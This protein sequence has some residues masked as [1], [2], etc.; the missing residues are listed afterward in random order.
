[1]ND[2][3]RRELIRRRWLLGTTAT[4]AAALGLGAALWRSRFEPDTAAES[5]PTDFWSLKWADPSGKTVSMQ[6]FRGQRLVLNF[7]ATWCPPCVEELPLI[8]DFYQKNKGNGWQVVGLAID[9]PSAVDAFLK[10]TPLDFPIALAMTDGLAL[11]RHLGNLSGGLPFSVVFGRD[12][13]VAQR[14]IGQINA[15]DLLRWHELK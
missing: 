7:W 14:K 8:N 5:L 13:Q 1:M 6:S 12:G 3:K 15:A 4:A 9:K 10:K 2:E 11:A